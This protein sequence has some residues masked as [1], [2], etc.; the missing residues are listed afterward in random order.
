[1]WGLLSNKCSLF[2]FGIKPVRCSRWWVVKSDWNTQQLHGMIMVSMRRFYFAFDLLRV[3]VSV[4]WS[5]WAGNP[6][7]RG[8]HDHLSLRLPRWFQPWLQLRRVH[9]LCHAALGGLREDGDTGRLWRDAD[10]L[11]RLLLFIFQSK[12]GAVAIGSVR[13]CC[14]LLSALQFRQLP[15]FYIKSY[16]QL[17]KCQ[18]FY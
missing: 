2:I 13:Y 18:I 8:V 1:M 9:Q 11:V 10:N 14:R 3:F 15:S 6:E 12:K 7:W 4:F 5:L 16:F 17:Q